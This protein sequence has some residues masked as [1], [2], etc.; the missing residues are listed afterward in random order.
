MFLAALECD[1]CKN[2]PALRTAVQ[3]LFDEYLAAL[4]D[5]NESLLVT[6]RDWEPRFEAN[7]IENTAR[8]A[9]GENI[10]RLD[11]PTR[12]LYQERREMGA[13]FV[14]RLKD[15]LGPEVFN[16]LD[17]ARR[18]MPVAT[19]S[20]KGTLRQVDR[21]DKQRSITSGAAGKVR[22]KRDAASGVGQKQ[23]GSGNK[24]R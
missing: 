5:A 10:R 16:E 15:L 19:A 7:A 1:A 13:E 3:N 18:F 11:D 2:D 8:R 17:G 4:D 23:P 22:D 20:E 9:R 12:P 14:E 21:D 24:D 6:T